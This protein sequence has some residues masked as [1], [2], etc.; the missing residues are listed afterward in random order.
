M[1]VMKG[2]PD[3]LSDVKKILGRDATKLFS[4]RQEGDTVYVKL[5]LFTGI[6]FSERVE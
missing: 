2:K 5:Q 4:F 3:T 1:I 6:P